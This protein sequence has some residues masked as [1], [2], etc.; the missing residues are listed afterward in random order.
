ML[1]IYP[2]KI[3]SPLTSTTAPIDEDDDVIPVLD[4]ENLPPGPNEATLGQDRETAEPIQYEN[5]TAETGPGN[6]TGVTRGFM[7]AARSWPTSTAVSRKIT[8]YDAEALRQNLNDITVLEDQTEGETLADYDLVRMDSDG[9]W[10]LTDGTDSA[11]VPGLIGIR[12]G[13]GRVQT[14]GKITNPS[15]TFT[16]ADTAYIGN[17]PGQISTTPGTYRRTIG[18][19]LA[20]TVINLTPYDGDPTMIGIQ[21]YSGN[22]SRPVIGVEI[23]FSAV[24]QTEFAVASYDWDFGDESTHSTEKAPRHTYTTPGDYDVVLT[25]TDSQENTWTNHYTLHVYP[26]PSSAHQGKYGSQQPI[27]RIAHA[28]TIVNT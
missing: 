5:K 19:V 21:I 15:W 18:Q 12:I 3:N 20:A 28:I 14:A 23:A 4:L 9:S 11:K 22:S 24:I 7:G 6:L 8:A 13:D 27:T 10:Y 25:L 1:R 17:T 26:R 2:A 16:P